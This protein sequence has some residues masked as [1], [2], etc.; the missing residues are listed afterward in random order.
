MRR[1]WLCAILIGVLPVACSPALD[2]REVR[3]D[4][5][6]AVALFPCHPKRQSRQAALAGAPTRM[7]LWSCEAEGLTFALAQAELG[8]PARVTP[9]LA[10]MATALAANLQATEVL[11]E[12]AAVPGMTPNAEARRLRFSGRLPDGTAAHEQAVLF[13]HGTR[14][15]Q[16]A[17]LGARP[18]AAAQVFFDG[19]RVVP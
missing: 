1:A 19:L 3:P 10:E 14:V 9:A 17:V 2:W 5:S 6:A 13:A 4:G 8:D 11:R 15:F 7:T 18:D 16:A 12:P